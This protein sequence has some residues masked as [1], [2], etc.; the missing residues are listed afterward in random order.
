M[1][2]ELETPTTDGLS[3]TDATTEPIKVGTT[4][5]EVFH[6]QD[7]QSETEFNSKSDQEWH[8]TE[9]STGMN[10]LEEVNID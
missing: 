8:T 3:G 2:T 7:T 1:F 5:P 10:T 4:I 6:T 9:P